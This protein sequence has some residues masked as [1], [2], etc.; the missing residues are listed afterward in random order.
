VAF[1]TLYQDG[2]HTFIVATDDNGNPIYSLQFG[3]TDLGSLVAGGNSTNVIQTQGAP[4]NPSDYQ[5][6]PQQ[7]LQEGSLNQ[8]QNTINQIQNAVGQQD[9]SNTPYNPYLGPNCNSDLHSILQQIGLDGP[10]P[11]FAPGWYDPVNGPHNLQ[12]ALNDLKQQ[13]LNILNQLVNG[14]AQDPYESSEDPSGE[15]DGDEGVKPGLA[16]TLMDNLKTILQQ[17]E[18]LQNTGTPIGLPQLQIFEQSMLQDSSQFIGY[19]TDAG[20]D[21]LGNGLGQDAADQAGSPPSLFQNPPQK[22]ITSNQGTTGTSGQLAQDLL[23]Q[24]ASATVLDGSGGNA[25]LVGYSGDNT[26]I[27]GGNVTAFGGTGSNPYL[28]GANTYVFGKAALAAATAATPTITTVLDYD[29]GFTSTYFDP[30]IG[31]ATSTYNLNDPFGVAGNFNSSGNDQ[32][33]VSALVSAAYQQGKGEPVGDLVR[34]IIEPGAIPGSTFADL[35][36]NTGGAGPA[37]WVTIAQLNGLHLGDPLSVILDPGI[38]ASQVQ[39]E[40]DPAYTGV[41]A[42]GAVS[43]PTGE[44]SAGK[45]ITLTLTMSHA[46]TVQQSS[47]SPLTLEL[48]NGGIATYDATASNPASEKLVFDY[49]VGSN[50]FVNG[51][52]TQVSDLEITFVNDASDVTDASTGNYADFSLAIG[53]YTGIQPNPTF[54]TSVSPTNYGSLPTTGDVLV[55][56]SFQIRVTLNEG[57]VV[58]TASG[59]P[60]LALSD[61]G[62][63]TYDASASDPAQGTLIFD[64]TVAAKDY[65]TALAVTGLDPNGATIEDT[66]GITPDFSEIAQ[67]LS[68]FALEL[69]NGFS[70]YDVNAAI[71][72]SVTPSLTSVLSGQEVQLTLKMS[73][74][75]TVDTN[76]GLPTLLL[77]D[78]AT[79]I[80]DA[81]ASNPTKGQ[82]VFDYTV[83][84]KDQTSDLSILEVN[85]PSGST[86]QDNQGNNADFTLAAFQNVGLQVGPVY[87]N[88]VVTSQTEAGHAGQTVELSVDLSQGVLVNTGGGLPTLTLNDG[89]IATYD[90]LK[91]DP[92]IGH[93]VFDY[94]V[95]ATDETPDLKI[96]KV[97]LPS[98]TTVQDVNGVNANLAGTLNVSTDLSINSPLS[99]RSI[100]SSLTGTASVG[101]YVTLTV[102]MKEGMLMD[103]TYGLPVLT[104]ND[105][106][107]ATYDPYISNPSNGILAFDYTIGPNDQTSN[108]AVTGIRLNGS[109]YV[110]APYG[111]AT[112]QD[113]N[114]YN[115]DFSGALNVGTGLQVTPAAPVI[116]SVASSVVF[117]SGE[118]P[119]QLAPNLVLSDAGSSTLQFAM[120][121]VTAGAFSGDGDVLTANTSG[122]SITA[123]YDGLDE[124]LL[125]TGA[126]S[127][128]NYQKVLQSVAFS[129]SGQDPTSSGL[130]PGRT[131]SWVAGDATNTSLEPTTT[132]SVGAPSGADTVIVNEIYTAVLQ[133]L[134]TSA[135]LMGAIS[136]QSTVGISGLIAT[137]LGS[138]EAQANVYPIAQIIEL[139]TGNMP[140]TGQLAGWVPFVE[141]NGLLQGSSQTNPLLDQMAEAF[142]ASAILIM[143]AR[144]SIRTPPSRA[145]SSRPSSR[146]P[147]A[148]PP[149]R[150]RSMPGC[151]RVRPSIRCSSTLLS[152]INTQPISRARCSSSSPR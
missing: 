92:S 30:G 131:V 45:A 126:D 133:R 40:L 81:S 66:H 65:T 23:L 110:G 12:T 105:G 125:L 95:G 68:F 28:S 114:G 97:N 89:A 7:V 106:A 14:Q 63:A 41:A 67:P 61:G 32:I 99:V 82:L 77:N 91:S 103:I 35:Q 36:V 74:G 148:L 120:V 100:A 43:G 112:I 122:T 84:P 33:D 38:P 10:P 115:P 140:T 130:F 9:W 4:L 145:Q 16:S 46:V 149:P 6:L 98:G 31:S 29:Q 87:V 52:G 51:S 86:I 64:Y 54:V 53:A 56:Q 25:L 135:E 73:E 152:A 88:N 129:T 21:P 119:V 113:A 8:I 142:V 104:L 15:P 151:R 70:T 132:V 34:A 117:A 78:G 3:P 27:A 69:E 19:L 146:P 37:D 90:A 75:V 83:G 121:S 79:A 2:P 118:Q 55:G 96:T 5:N 76:G 85:L 111:L 139:A 109:L 144:R 108:L 137:V 17:I 107:T 57:V 80:Y 147:P 101:Q 24:G 127:V 116:S 48:N 47:F 42:V 13:A 124:L 93:L 60:T 71:V 44:I 136:I 59:T 18:Q 11:G 49:T 138:P 72:T 22:P 1:I 150:P 128:A 123:T 141:T 143:A 58:D 102:T 62:M 50:P 134:P 39:V 94:T 20:Q 26:L